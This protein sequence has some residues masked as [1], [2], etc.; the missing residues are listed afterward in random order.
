[1]AKSIALKPMR[2][3]KASLSRF[4]LLIAIVSGGFFLLIHK[5]PCKQ[6]LTYSL[7]A[8]DTRFGMDREEFLQNLQASEAPWEE[9]AGR[10]LFRYEEGAPFKVDLIFDER[11]ERT[12][13]LSDIEGAGQ[14]ADRE[15]GKISNQYASLKA[16]YDQASHDYE[17]HVSSY[18]DRLSD[19]NRKVEMWNRRG[20]APEN[21]YDELADEKAALNKEGKAVESERQEVNALVARINSLAKKE[22]D[23]VEEY[24]T[25]I[26]NYEERYGPAQEFDQGEY[27]GRQINIYQ[28]RDATELRL[29][30]AHELGHALGIGH[31][32]NPQS[33][34]YYLM[35]KQEVDPILL[36]AEDRAAFDA[37]C[38][39][40]ASSFS[41]ANIA[42]TYRFLA[43]R[44]S[45]TLQSY[46]AAQ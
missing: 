17:K 23:L 36:T 10:E 22:E 1:M 29:V 14:E 8:F 12:Q 25:T 11:Q 27:V 45:Q 13:A 38:A 37:Y 40:P 19:Y 9:E 35:E 20:G 41:L 18:S 3:D 21:E 43:D 42:E 32:E 33:L 34:M 30:F 5:V 26:K 4:A 2:P 46:E 24:N 16:A 28:F 15:Q 7:G 31:V 6:V 44:F 39:H